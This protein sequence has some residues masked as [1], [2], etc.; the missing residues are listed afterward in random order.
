MDVENVESP[1]P[2]LSIVAIIAQE[3]EIMDSPDGEV[4]LS[5]EAFDDLVAQQLSLI[6]I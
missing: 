2:A 3:G 5:S 1:T 4:Q 6:H